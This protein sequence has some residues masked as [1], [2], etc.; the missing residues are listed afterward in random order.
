MPSGSRVA[1]QS[2]AGG[3]GAAI[4]LQA[5]ASEAVLAGALAAGRPRAVLAREH[6]ARAVVL[7]ANRAGPVSRLVRWTEAENHFLREN[8]GQLSEADIAAVLGRTVVAIHG[9]WHDRLRLRPPSKR[10]EV[11][12]TGQRIADM[13]GVDAHSVMLWIRRGQLPARLLPCRGRRIHLVP[14]L[15][16][17]QF[18]VNP[19]NWPF[20]KP[21]HITDPH[22]K[23]LVERQRERWGDEWW[24][25]G[26]TA[27]HHR[28]PQRLVNKHI[29]DGLLPAV[30]AGNYRIR[31]SDAV[32]H[33]FIL[34]KCNAWS[35][36]RWPTAANAFLVTAAA[37]GYPFGAIARL[38]GR[39]D[40]DGETVRIHL[41][42]LERKR[43][44]RA[45]IAEHGLKARYDARRRLLTADWRE[46]R[47]QFPRLARTMERL[48]AGERLTLVERSQALGVLRALARWHART[49]R[50]KS[51]VKALYTLGKRN[52]RHLRAAADELAGWGVAVW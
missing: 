18:V 24:T 50:Q 15:A 8:I 5:I 34:G 21:E 32:A 42:L 1:A 11:E 37:L 19:L 52:E 7:S 13:L 17:L 46:H 49:T 9:Q 25:V 36:K 38:M 39:R 14:R 10:P 45:I 44:I 41:R 43:R 31:R 16:F 2:S 47:T 20:F 22:L 12:L 48:A 23:R 51:L 4:D 33:R 27:R 30:D 28:V 40:D 29:H 3:P 26:Q 35:E 6:G